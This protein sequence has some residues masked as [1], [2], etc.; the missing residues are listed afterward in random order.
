MRRRACNFH[1]GWEMHVCPIF[2]FYQVTLCIVL[3]FIC[4][5][6]RKLLFLCFLC[7]LSP[8]S[9]LASRPSSHLAILRLSVFQILDVGQLFS[10]IG[11]DSRSSS[12]SAIWYLPLRL[13]SGLTCYVRRTG[14][15]G[16]EVEAPGQSGVST[17]LTCGPSCIGTH[18][19]DDRRRWWWQYNNNNLMCKKKMLII[20]VLMNDNNGQ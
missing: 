15:F 10:N 16:S 12:A 11:L 19:H 18:D 3:N 5:Y 17:V 14:G 2:Y 4:F 1:L 20:I 7:V 8:T 6:Q 9:R 13:R